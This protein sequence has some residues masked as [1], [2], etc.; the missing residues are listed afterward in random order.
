MPPTYDSREKYKRAEQQLR[1]LL[2]GDAMYS[3]GAVKGEEQR[4]KVSAQLRVMREAAAELAQHESDLAD[5]LLKATQRR[6][7]RQAPR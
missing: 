4:A 5:E 1:D 3:R 6:T 2:F 7:K